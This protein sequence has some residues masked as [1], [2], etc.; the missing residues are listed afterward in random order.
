MRWLVAIRWL[1]YSHAMAECSHAM[2]GTRN[3]YNYICIDAKIIVFPE[4]Y[5]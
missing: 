1:E 4:L 3:W 5:S 2:A